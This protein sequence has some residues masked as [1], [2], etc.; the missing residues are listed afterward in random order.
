MCAAR[1]RRRVAIPHFPACHAVYSRRA[2]FLPQALWPLIIVLAGLPRIVVLAAAPVH[3]VKLET[4]AAPAEAVVVTAR[5][6]NI[7]RAP[8]HREAAVWLVVQHHDELRAIIRLAVQRLVRDDERRSRQCG[9]R[10][11]IEY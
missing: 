10:D 5:G 1:K 8:A 11:T 7:A 4:P 9:R 6:A 3:I 2:A